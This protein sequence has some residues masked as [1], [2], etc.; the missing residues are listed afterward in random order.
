MDPKSLL[1]L[2]DHLEALSKDGDLAERAEQG[3]AE[4]HRCA[5][6]AQ[7]RWQG[8]SSRIEPVFAGQKHRMGL[9]IRP[10]A[11]ARA[12]IKIG[13]ANLA[14]NVQPLAWIEGRGAPA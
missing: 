12:R 14:C 3:G 10:I 7:G 11:I 9:C 2:R 5:L 4:R 13:M 6:D 1:S 8:A